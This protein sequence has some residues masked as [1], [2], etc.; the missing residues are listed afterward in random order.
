MTSSQPVI[1]NGR[2]YKRPTVP[3]VVVCIDGS[4]PGYIEEAIEAGVAPNF[5]R[6]M[7]TGANLIA[8]CVIPS[9]TNPNNLSIIT[10]GRRPC[11]ASPATSSTTPPPAPR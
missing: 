10:G 2:N 1:V 5:A 7:K 6:F 4:E 8:E 9:F 3:T 11:M